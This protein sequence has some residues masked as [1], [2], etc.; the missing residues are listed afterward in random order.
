MGSTRKGFNRGLV[1]KN[2]R[3]VV[4]W[5]LQTPY[6]G[7]LKNDVNLGFWV[8]I[9]NARA[10]GPKFLWG[11]W[12]VINSFLLTCLAV[13]YSKISNCVAFFFL[14]GHTECCGCVLL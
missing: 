11:L 6:G 1:G 8:S 2:E 7:W 13:K 4:W 14:K 3:Q 10:Q 5:K 12:T 9:K